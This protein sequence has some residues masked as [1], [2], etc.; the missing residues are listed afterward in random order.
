MQ[1][2][3]TTKHPNLPQIGNLNRSKPIGNP[4]RKNQTACTRPTSTSRRPKLNS[5]SQQSQPHTNTASHH[6]TRTFV[7]T[8][9]HISTVTTKRP[10]PHLHAKANPNIHTQRRTTQPNPPSLHFVPTIPKIST[11]AANVCHLAT[12]GLPLIPVECHTQEHPEFSYDWFKKRKKVKIKR[13]LLGRCCSAGQRGKVA[14]QRKR[15]RKNKVGAYFPVFVRSKALKNSSSSP[16]SSQVSSKPLKF[17]SRLKELGLFQGI[18][19]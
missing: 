1:P 19:I 9:N 13:R 10:K 17:F 14:V 12:T 15:K 3:Q 5:L 8:S 2:I 11:L 16:R 4:I 18:V 7:S 6:H